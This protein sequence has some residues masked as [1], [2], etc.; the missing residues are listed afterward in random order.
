MVKRIQAEFT[1]LMSAPVG[2]MK[3]AAPSSW[4][5]KE[6]PPLTDGERVTLFDAGGL[7]VEAAV[8]QD[9]AGWW[10]ATPEDATWRDTVSLELP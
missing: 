6:L 10:I 9:D 3:P 5:G 1:T 7:E 2:I 4:Q 8:I